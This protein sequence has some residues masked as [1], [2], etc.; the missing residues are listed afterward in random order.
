MD[1]SLNQA[2]ERREGRAGAVLAHRSGE[3]GLA[4]AVLDDFFAPLANMSVMLL[5]ERGFVVFCFCGNIIS[6]IVECSVSLAARW[7]R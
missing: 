7:I 3:I 4:A 5:A 1:L 6:G 2:D